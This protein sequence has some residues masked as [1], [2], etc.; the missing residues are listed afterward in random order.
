MSRSGSHIAG[1]SFLVLLCLCVFMQVLG[2]PTSLWNLELE[3]DVLESSILEALSI[4]TGR[5][6]QG[7]DRSWFCR[8]DMCQFPA[9]VL[10]DGG[11]FRPPCLA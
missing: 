5:V 3:E 11:L 8:S 4:P 10:S 7:R 2:A 6:P 9:D 1:S